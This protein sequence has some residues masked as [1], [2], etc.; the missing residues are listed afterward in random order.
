MNTK[1]SKGPFLANVGLDP[2]IDY[3]AGFYYGSIF[4]NL[5][6]NVQHDVIFLL[7]TNQVFARAFGRGSGW[8]FANSPDEIK[9]ILMGLCRSNHE[10]AINFCLSI[11]NH[12]GRLTEK[13]MK[14]LIDLAADDSF[15]ASRLGYE[16]GYNFY[17]LTKDLKQ[18]VFEFADLRPSFAHEFGM[19][20]KNTINRLED[21]DKKLVL[22]F[23]DKNNFF[24]I[25]MSC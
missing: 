16:I 12:L 2:E 10:L 17:K 21:Q 3:E 9:R 20:V 19:G 1:K 7:S 6:V 18:I 23:V 5:D 15:F 22:D 25:G 14:W 8:R 13:S 11:G 4:Y 24:A